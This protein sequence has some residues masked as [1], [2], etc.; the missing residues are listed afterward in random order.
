MVVPTESPNGLETSHRVSEPTGAL[1]ELFVGGCLLGAA[2]I[3]GLVFVR[4]PW[5]N[6]LDAIGFRVLPADL[7]A[8]WAADLAQLG[9][10]TVLVAGVA[11]LCV[12]AATSRNWTRAMSCLIAPIAAVLIVQTVAKPLV[13]RHIEGALSYPSG[14]VTAVAALAAGAFLVTPRFAKL[15]AFVTGGMVVAAVCA[16]VVVLRWHFPTDALGGV[17]VG[18]G[19]VFAVDGLLLS[20]GN[21]H[22][23]RRAVAALHGRSVTS[24]AG[25]PMEITES[26]EAMGHRP[27]QDVSGSVSGK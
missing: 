14:T 5:P 16:A 12:V 6:R 24:G 20:I 15:F 17:C 2:A 4:R 27:L 11:I 19:A 13:G 18:A 22:P 26:S 21:Q 7:S 8:K 10:L 25:T 1:T 3:A 23:L 9:S